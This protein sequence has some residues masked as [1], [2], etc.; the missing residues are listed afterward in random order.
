ML[1]LNKWSLS[2]LGNKVELPLFTIR[3]I[4]RMNILSKL[5]LVCTGTAT[6]LSFAASSTLAVIYD[7]KVN[8]FSGELI[9]QTFKGWV[10]FDDTNLKGTGFEY[11]G[12]EFENQPYEF[13][14]KLNFN[15]SFLDQTLTE[16]DDKLGITYLYFKDGKPTHIYYDLDDYQESYQGVGYTIWFSTKGGT[17]AEG[18]PTPKQEFEY[19]FDYPYQ[20]FGNGTVEFEKRGVPEPN[21]TLGLGIISLGVVLKQGVKRLSSPTPK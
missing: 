6:V 7:F 18:N 10:E 4:N 5:A 2:C 17:D 20:W 1:L 21:A 13:D 16:D 11:T 19:K 9:G 14:G 8:I 3:E 15:F 12:I